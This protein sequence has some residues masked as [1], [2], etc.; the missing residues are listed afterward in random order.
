MDTKPDGEVQEENLVGLVVAFYE[1]KATKPSDYFFVGH[2][3]KIDLTGFDETE[4]KNPI[5]VT[6]LDTKNYRYFG[7]TQGDVW[8]VLLEDLWGNLVTYR[9]GPALTVDIVP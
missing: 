3:T 7:L 1:N 8:R 9:K 2:V 4:I 6:S 5:K